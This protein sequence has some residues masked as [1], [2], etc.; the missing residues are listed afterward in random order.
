VDWA[1]LIFVLVETTAEFSGPETRPARMRSGQAQPVLL[2]EAG[3]GDSGSAKSFSQISETFRAAI[4]GIKDGLAILAWPRLGCGRGQ[5]VAQLLQSLFGQQ[6]TIAHPLPS[7]LGEVG[8]PCFSSFGVGY[9]FRG[10]KS[11]FQ[12]SISNSLPS[13]SRLIEMMTG[14]W[15][16]SM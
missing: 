10:L 4:A 2:S 1:R 13:W 7:E 12:K 6:Q 15:S 11:T 8:C 16:S 9:R 3:P 14:I 5:M